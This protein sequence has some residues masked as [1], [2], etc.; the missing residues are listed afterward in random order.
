[1]SFLRQKKIGGIIILILFIIALL[2]IGTWA[3]RAP[4]LELTLN[5]LPKRYKV[6]FDTISNA[7]NSG[8]TIKNIDIK[9]TE[10]GASLRADT[11]SWRPKLSTFLEKSIG[12]IK[13]I[14][15]FVKLNIEAKEDSEPSSNSPKLK[16]NSL[17]IQGGS[18][19]I[20]KN[21]SPF[22]FLKHVD[23]EGG[24]FQLADK[25]ISSK[26]QSLQI[27]SIALGENKS[28]SLSGLDSKFSFKENN[29]LFFDQLTIQNSNAEITPSFVKELGIE[30]QP[31]NSQSVEF[32]FSVSIEKLSAPLNNIKW[33]DLYGSTFLTL[34]KGTN[35]GA[36][37]LSA[38]IK[39]L[40]HFSSQKNTGFIDEIALRNLSVLDIHNKEVIKATSGKTTLKFNL[41]DSTSYLET[42]NFSLDHPTI[43]LDLDNWI[44]TDTQ[45][46]ALPAISRPSLHLVI[47]DA[48]INGG[49]FQLVGKGHIP[50]VIA[51]FD[52][53]L[54]NLSNRAP[55]SSNNQ[56][57][58]FTTLKIT[59]VTPLS[60]SEIENSSYLIDGSD[61]NINLN[62]ENFIDNKQIEK[63]TATHLD[64]NFQ[65]APKSP[66][67]QSENETNNTPAIWENIISKSTNIKNGEINL[68]GLG[69][70]VPE[71]KTK[72]QLEGDDT[73]L[74][75]TLMDLDLTLEGSKNSFYHASK[76][77]IQVDPNKA[78]KEREI[79]DVTVL[80]GR[81]S[82]SEELQSLTEKGE[83]TEKSNKSSTTTPWA[84]NK[85]N[86]SK[87]KIHIDQLSPLLPPIEFEVEKSFDNFS[88]D[89]KQFE[90]SET[91]ESLT[92]S[93]L[94]ILSP[95]GN[96]Y[97]K[98]AELENTSLEFTMG[99]IFRKE[100]NRVII[101]SPKLNI[102]KSLFWYID[103]Y[104]R[105]GPEGSENK[106]TGDSSQKWDVKEIEV[107]D[108]KLRSSPYQPLP[109]LDGLTQPF[110]FSTTVKGD[111][112]QVKLV[113]SP[114]TYTLSEIPLTLEK[115]EGKVEFNLPLP[116]KDN[117]LVEVLQAQK[118]IFKQFQSTNC[119][120]S[121]TYDEYGV[122]GHFGGEFY[123][124]YLN[125][126]FNIYSNNDST[127]DAWVSA[128]DV[129]A[130]SIFKIV[131]PEYFKMTGKLTLNV[132]GAGDKDEI[133]SA[134]GTLSSSEPG[135]IYIAA[136]DSFRD[137]LPENWEPLRL[138]LIKASLHTMQNFKYQT[139]TGEFNVFGKEGSLTL[140]VMGESGKRSFEVN[141]H[142]YR[143]KP[144]KIL[145]QN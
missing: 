22:M 144:K 42:S 135:Y 83:G 120:L 107:V 23:F 5:N 54:S 45:N 38:D 2:L 101:D 132:V 43:H 1:M 50:A 77:K 138:A 6:S 141:V 128:T 18:F 65:G 104:R 78:W 25:K 89:L 71:I 94:S 28:L 51:D 126:G 61:L 27:E 145:K 117:N 123:D 133:Y 139:A 52:T 17:S 24:D 110:P 64:F 69:E 116:K 63:L 111:D 92:I 16:W 79:S 106:S 130:D 14:K 109:F 35:S 31:N 34:P 129:D 97:D 21:N 114:D 62:P 131:S 80:G 124:G 86:V 20:T 32:L 15:P 100:I 26:A 113:I 46:K 59:N 134:K 36:L 105:F 115:L 67:G 119:Y 4:I 30:S 108:G 19:E 91:P 74:E 3:L 99:G 127:W 48:N 96:A 140:D 70:N 41:T 118:I 57:L 82:V 103:Y 75:A 9:D 49:S 90:T 29:N 88:M 76:A 12:D 73:L 122:Y 84:I 112:L 98:V 8:I 11:L 143:D 7:K 136:L 81:L 121:V 60:P 10:L 55:Y 58:R 102:G 13:V 68:T 40:C 33:R 95:Y 37:T 137:R 142:D 39:T 85:L 44:P 87:T 56:L 66:N 53:T 93:N 72:Y 125:G 47:N